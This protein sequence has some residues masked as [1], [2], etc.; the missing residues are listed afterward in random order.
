MAHKNIVKT[1]KA[2]KVSFRLEKQF[3][4]EEFPV[5][6]LTVLVKL[7]NPLFIRSNLPS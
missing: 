6:I 1:D 2:I 5:L 3:F 4:T 7:N